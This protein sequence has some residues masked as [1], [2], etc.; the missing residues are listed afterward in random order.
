MPDNLTSDPVY[1]IKNWD[2]MKWPAKPLKPIL[3]VPRWLGGAMTVR[4]I[5][6]HKWCHWVVLRPAMWIAGLRHV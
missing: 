5:M 3:V 4:Y 1:E 6:T 2:P